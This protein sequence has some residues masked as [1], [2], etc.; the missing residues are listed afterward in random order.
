M[1]TVNHNERKHALLSASGAYRWLA[2]P[3]SA[4][5][6]QKFEETSPETSSVYADEGTLAHELSELFLRNFFKDISQ[7]VY[8]EE[9]SKLIK[10]PLYTSEMDYEVE[11]YTTFVIEEFDNSK[12]ITPDA[13]LLI[14]KR[15]DFSHIIEQGFGTGD[16]C[17]L[18]DRKFS[19]IDLKYGKGIKVDAKDNPQLMLYALGAIREFDILYD[20]EEVELII[21]QPRLDH[22]SR[23]TIKLDKLQEWAEKVVKPIAEKASQG[24]GLQKAGDHC[25]FCKVKAM[26]AT[27]AA[28]NVALAKHEFKDPHLLTEKQLL[29]VYKQQP[30]LVDW[31]NSVA[32]YLLSEALKGKKWEGYKLVEGKSNRRWLEENKVIEVLKKAEFDPTKF[33]VTKLAGITDIEQL[34][35]KKEFSTI[36]GDLVVKP[37]GKPTLVPDS[38]KRPAMGLE[39]AKIDF[40][41]PIPE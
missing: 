32:D 20:F 9:R 11:K 33:M 41:T 26:C 39:Q 34:V 25:K 30:M 10:S 3:P 40:D 13:K 4:R 24:K 31:V 5:L 17:I 28:K 7:K 21:V 37:Q 15:F 29:D 38:D 2:C 6:E 12:K 18:S 27:L 35:G 36:L 14:E 22:V 8:D 1:G 16:T 19:I 23:W